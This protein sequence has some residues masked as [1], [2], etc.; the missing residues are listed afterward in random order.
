MT[1]EWDDAYD[2]WLDSDP[3]AGHSNN[4]AG[5][6]L[7]LMIWLDHTPAA[8]PIPPQVA[9]EV[10]IGANTFDI[11]HGGDNTA[12]YVLSPPS[13]TISVD[14]YDV[15]K[16]AIA[17]GYAQPSWYVTDVE[18]GFE[19]WNGGAGLGCANFTVNT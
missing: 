18:F 15:I 4:S 8:Q 3:N 7:E 1:G 2:I 14:L 9:S 17:R 6:H 16:D 12:S 5:D 10:K 13:D 11:W 19:I